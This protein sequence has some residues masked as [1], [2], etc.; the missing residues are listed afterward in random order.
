MNVPFR[1]MMDALKVFVEPIVDLLHV[2]ALAA[3]FT[4]VD[5]RQNA[6][7]IVTKAETGSN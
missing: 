7:L 3:F 5:S 1:V 6:V 2:I 4:S